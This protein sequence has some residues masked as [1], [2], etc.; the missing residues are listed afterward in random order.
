MDAG[1]EGSVPWVAQENIFS[2]E[3]CLGSGT[4]HRVIWLNP[5]LGSGYSPATRPGELGGLRSRLSFV[6]RNFLPIGSN[7]S[8]FR[9]PGHPPGLSFPLG[10]QT[11]FRME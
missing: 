8:L 4:S 11:V 3:G 9:P 6:S 10:G 1:R 7:R 5:A 2:E